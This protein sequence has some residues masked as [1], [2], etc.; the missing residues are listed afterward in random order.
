MSDVARSEMTHRIGFVGAGQMAQALANG[1]LRAQRVTPECLFGCDPSPHARAAFE[2]LAPGVTTL[3]SH[4]ALAEQSDVIVLAVKPQYLF[5]AAESLRPFVR[6]QLVVSIVAGAS[7]SDL[8]KLLETERLVRVMPNTPALVGAGAA[9]F[10]LGAGAT[11]VDGQLVQQWLEAIGIA[12]CVPEPQLNAVTGLSGS[13][14][15]Y[16]FVMLEALAD[17]GVRMG[18]PRAV[19]QQLAAQTLMGAARLQLETGEHPAVLKDR[20]ASPGGTTIAGLHVL[21][22]H[23]VRGALISAVEAATRRAEELGDE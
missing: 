18:L 11:E 6:D 3:E 2:A 12:F 4:Q 13:G 7:L 5:E 14:P 20:V 1:L 22:D 23:G 10:S 17:G 16:V 8:A 15:A 9:G 19:A 21:E